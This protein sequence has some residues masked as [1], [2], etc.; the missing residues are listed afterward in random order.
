MNKL[1]FAA[2]VFI[3]FSTIADTQRLYTTE[4]SSALTMVKYTENEHMGKTSKKCQLVARSKR[5]DWISHIQYWYESD[6][7]YMAFTLQSKSGRDFSDVAKA[8]IDPIIGFSR[9]VKV[10]RANDKMVI[11]EMLSGAAFDANDYGGWVGSLV[12]FGSSLILYSG[13]Q[14]ETV[15]VIYETNAR[16]VFENCIEELDATLKG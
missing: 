4:S 5:N 14:A 12:G 8:T 9:K 6:V 7:R 3:S 1:L 15:T 2:I 10:N 11:V 16:P 13:M